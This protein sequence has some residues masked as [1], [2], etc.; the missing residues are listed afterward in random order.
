[1]FEHKRTFGQHNVYAFDKATFPFI[2]YLHNVYSTTDMSQLHVGY[3]EFFNV[4]DIE[5]P[6]HKKFYKAIKSDDQF[7]NMYCDMIRAIHLQFFP[8]EPCLIYQSFPSIRLQFPGSVAIQKHCD[9]DAI[10]SHPL[11]E[12][13]FIIPLTRMTKTASV[14]IESEPGKGDFESQELEYGDLFYFNGNT[15]I[16]HNEPNQENYLRVSFDFRVVP[17]SSYYK[18]VM[19]TPIIYTRPRD[20]NT[21]RKPVMITIGGYYQVVFRDAPDW[22][23]YHTKKTIVQSRPTFE[24]EETQAISEYIHSGDPFYTEFK[25]TEKLEKYICDYMNVKHCSMVTSGTAA[26]ICALLAC[27]VGQGDEVV[28]PAYTMV[29]TFNAVK[30]VGAAPVVI[31][32]SR[33]TWT[34]TPQDVETA[35][36]PRTKA[37]I[38]VSLNNRDAGLGAVSEICKKAGVFLIEDAAQSV[39][40]LRYG[41]VGDVACFSLSTPKIISTGQG[42]FT[43]TNNE[44]LGQKIHMIKNFG[45]ATGGTEKYDTFGLNFKYTDL[46]AVIGL[47]QFK[48]LPQRVQRY[49]EIGALYHKYVPSIKFSSFPWFVDVV[50]ENRDALAKFLKLHGIETRV[51]YPA[52]ADVPNATYISSHGLFLPTHMAL[53]NEE[54]KHICNLLNAYNCMSVGS[55]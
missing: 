31:D 51:C 36:T 10:G 7:K 5:T 16:H 6:L 11:G 24:Y 20:E 21:E 30:S 22:E 14:Y 34:V 1:M 38:H 50:V 12:R 48:K 32:V 3:E 35:L 8:D 17:P 54:I 40:C 41:T 55:C 49:K 43:V 44:S 52:L 53:T 39:G 18:Y 2:E 42:G 46:Q 45:R 27:G 15:C 13:N 37:V 29:A 33:E 28:L 25:E 47:A 23:W 9:S 4:N 26:L 19:N